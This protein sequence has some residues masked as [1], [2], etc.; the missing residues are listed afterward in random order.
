MTFVALLIVAKEWTISHWRLWQT[1]TCIYMHTT[2]RLHHLS[3]HSH[4]RAGGLK[5]ECTSGWAGGRLKTRLMALPPVSCPVSPRWGPRVCFLSAQVMLTLMAQ[6]S[7]SE[8]PCENVLLSEKSKFR[9][10]AGSKM[11]CLY[12]T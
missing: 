2:E 9:K 7:H 8:G 6:T 3:F 1:A 11:Q 12:V 5:L 10:S 4:C